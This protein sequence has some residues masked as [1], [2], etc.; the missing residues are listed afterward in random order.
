MLPASASDSVARLRNTQHD[1]TSS[2]V[3]SERDIILPQEGLGCEDAPHS[4]RARVIDKNVENNL[5]N[6]EL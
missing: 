2:R 5:K 3:S 4:S 6:S 1:H